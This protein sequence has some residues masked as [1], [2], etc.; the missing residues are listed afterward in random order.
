M[1]IQMSSAPISADNVQASTNA[2][3]H[4]HKTP[5]F[6]KE[7]LVSTRNNDMTRSCK[8]CR[9]RKIRCDR[10]NP[11]SY[12]VKN[13][14]DCVHP[15]VNRRKERLNKSANHIISTQLENLEV[16]VRISGEG[17]PRRNGS[18]CDL[19]TSQSEAQG[20]HK[21]QSSGNSKSLVAENE[22]LNNPGAGIGRSVDKMVPYQPVNHSLWR[23]KGQEVSPFA[24]LRSPPPPPRYTRQQ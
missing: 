3:D 5:L 6:S 11:C 4:I 15:R 14:I 13:R 22:W 21:W 8:E 19:S 16:A 18:R 1:E 20:P 9:R 24:L 12:C 17:A 10:G 23:F 2:M 7:S